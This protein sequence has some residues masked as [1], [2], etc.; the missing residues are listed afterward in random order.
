MTVAIEP[1]ATGAT[2][3]SFYSVFRRKQLARIIH[4]IG[5]NQEALSQIPSR[6]WLVQLLELCQEH[7]LTGNDWNQ[8]LTQAI[9]YLL[10]ECPYRQH[11]GLDAQ[12][13]LEAIA[14]H[15]KDLS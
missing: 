12:E 14:H 9:H 5:R 15:L 10:Y 2:D 13:F 4:H 1:L 6:E 8:T 3:P 7:I 11:F